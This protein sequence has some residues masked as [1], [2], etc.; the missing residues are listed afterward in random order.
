MSSISKSSERLSADEIAGKSDKVHRISNMVEVEGFSDDDLK[1]KKILTRDKSKKDLLNLFR[2][3]RTTLHKQAGDNNYICV[4]TSVAS[5]SGSSYIANNLAAAIALDELKTALIVDCNIHAPSAHHLLTTNYQYGLTD[6]LSNQQMVAEDIIYASGVPRIRV[7]PV[8]SNR[9][10]G[11]ELFSNERMNQFIREI[12]LR[13][14]DRFIII[15]A[16]PAGE[17]A[18][19]THILSDLA[20]FTLLVVPFGKVTAQQITTAAEAITPEKLIGTIFNN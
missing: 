3:L 13:Y 12:R 17:F 15:E 5:G 7:V 8:G 19:E 16:P 9:E 11:A 18:A 20:D 10:N 1:E 6:Y 2:S 4:I 14:I